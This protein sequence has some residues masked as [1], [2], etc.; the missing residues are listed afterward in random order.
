MEDIKVLKEE[1]MD[2]KQKVEDLAHRNMRSNLVF[3]N[4][5]A[6]EGKSYNSAKNV[7]ANIIKENLK[8]EDYSCTEWSEL[9]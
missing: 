7:L 6:T 2:L 9:W 8:T 4:I 1:N 5:P 3:T